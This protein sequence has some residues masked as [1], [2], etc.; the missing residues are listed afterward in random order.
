MSKY[1]ERLLEEIE[2][3]PEEMLPKFCKVIHLLSSEFVSTPQKSRERGSLKAIWKG[4]Q[5]DEELF[6]QAKESLFPY[7]YKGRR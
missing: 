6:V 1:R 5:I 4:S 2:E 3:I 7:E